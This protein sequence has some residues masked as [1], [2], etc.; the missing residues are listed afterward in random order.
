MP[1]PSPG[2]PSYLAFLSA[3]VD[4]AARP[5]VVMAADGVITWA[6]AGIEDV[7]GYPPAQLVGTNVLELVHPDDVARLFDT[8]DYMSSNPRGTYLP[9]TF[10]F[11]HADG[12]YR[13][14]EV[15]TRDLRDDPLVGG[16]VVTMADVSD[17]ALLDEVLESVASG[18]PLA[19]TLGAIVA[20]LDTQLGER[21]A[22][23]AEPGPDGFAVAVSDDVPLALRGD[24]PIGID[25]EPASP[26]DAAARSRR[27]VVLEG[28]GTLD[29]E[30]REPA[31]AAGFAALWIWPVEH[32]ATG[33][34][35]ACITVWSRRAGPP[36]PGRRLAL[37]R[38]VRLV[39][40]ALE[41][42][43]Y[44]AMLL[45]AARHDPLTGAA[46]RTRFFEELR[47]IVVDG[48][49]PGPAQPGVHRTDG[50][51]AR[52]AGIEPSSTRAAVL[53]LDLDGFKAVNDRRGH[54]V[55][56]LVLQ[57]V[58]RRIAAQV[59]P[60]DLVAR[61]G[62]DEFAVLC[63]GL[64]D[65]GEAGV[66]ADR[67]I[68]AVSRPILVEG[69][70]VAVG[71]SIGIAFVDGRI[72]DAA[73]AVLPPTV[74]ALMEAADRALYEVKSAGKGAWRVAAVEA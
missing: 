6:S 55:G 47:R 2:D 1:A 56:D 27:P 29:A 42:H 24:V 41:R 74:D 48:R 62:G 65:K 70:E 45:H 7:G 19:A 63:G 22:L 60:D 11:R 43:A 58:T 13:P 23:V 25:D 44:D 28:L 39:R 18:T 15:T 30:W 66:I 17:R 54:R 51:A 36:S 73:P 5:L 26:W 33:A 49:R 10:R 61:F 67:L 69:D 40:L 52:G 53:Y 4:G 68:E 71:A 37:Q 8:Y 16:L 32:P 64:E 3:V 20:L 14:F 12:T 46:N 59:R 72:D 21:A 38:A 9:S 50:D 31:A 34:L 57:V 35:A